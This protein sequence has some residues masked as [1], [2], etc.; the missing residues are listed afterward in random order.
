[1]VFNNDSRWRFMLTTHGLTY[2]ILSIVILFLVI[3]TIIYGSL[4]RYERNLTRLILSHTYAVENG[5]IGFP[6]RLPNDG[7]YVQWTFLQM[8]DVYE[9]L[10]LDKGRKGGLARVAYLRQLLKEENSN[11]FTLLAGDLISPSALSTAIVNGTALNG[12]QMIATM[13]TLGLDYMTFGNHEFDYNHNELLLR[14]NE[15]K[16]T[17]ISTNVFQMNSS[18]SI[19]TSLTHKILTIDGVRILIIGLTV[20]SNLTYARFIDQASLINYIRQF[21]TQFPNGTYDVLVALT[22]LDIAQDIELA[23]KIP[24]IDLILGG[25]EHEDQYYLRGPKYIPLSK[26]DA[27]AFTVFIHRCA[28]NIDTKKLRIYS[29]LTRIT[30]DIPEEKETAIVAKYWYNLGIQAF[31]ALGYPIEKTIS[32]LPAG[33]ELDGRSEAVRTSQTS[34]SDAICESM[35][36]AASI[37]QSTIAIFNSGAIRIDDILRDTITGY[38]VIRILPYVNYI[39]VLS[40]PGQILARILAVGRSSKGNGMFLSYTGIQTPDQ[41]VTWLVNGIN[42]GTSG[43]NY[44]VVTIEYTRLYT[45]FNNPNITLIQTINIAQTAALMNYLQMKYPPC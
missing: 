39:Q 13:N 4:W 32:C 31:A 1:M 7:H 22:H 21:L 41:G 10:P 36:T 17:W 9:L 23:A 38:D 25:H 8:N 40:V 2:F 43:L 14:M 37:N 3:L 5:A 18:K 12:K 6:Q 11:T 30:S 26:A 28:Y 33:V 45:G 19:G 34:I 15:S 24:Q 27:N 42:V 20:P 29:T 35:I 16:F 44:T